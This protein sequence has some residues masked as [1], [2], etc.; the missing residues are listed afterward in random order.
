MT[1]QAGG[2]GEPPDKPDPFAPLPLATLPPV[3]RRGEPA[4]GPIATP[5][6][7]PGAAPAAPPVAPLAHEPVSWSPAPEPAPQAWTEPAV[8]V[9]GE[10]TGQSSGSVEPPLLPPT[11]NENALREAVGATPR[12]EPAP[13]KA[14]RRAAPPPSDPG[15][16]DGDDDGPR[17]RRSRRTVVVAALSILVGGGIAAT[18]V[19][20]KVNSARY[21][22][23]CEAEEVVIEQGRAF[24]PWGTR[25][26]DDPQWKPL[27]IPPE[28]ACHPRETEEPAELAGWYGRLLVDQATKLLTAREVT[29]VDDAEAILKQALLVSRSLRTDDDAKNSRTEIDRLLGDV[30]YWRASAR[31]RSAADTL[32]DAAKQF[33]AAA[34]QRPAHSTDASEWAAYARRLSD[35][36]RAGPSGSKAAAFPP[37]PPPE[38]ATGPTAPPG[39]ALPVEPDRG[40]GSA[41]PAPP[42]DAG[43]PTGGVLL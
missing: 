28:A 2:G 37:L 16:D 14:R 32:V 6:S 40:E 18:I 25:A 10:L 15:D 27:K 1:D 41:A 24:P 7:A 39:V 22:L 3:R 43:L 31:L 4:S 5:S 35:E 9:S 34:T 33:D 23:A 13:G 36:L 30:A 21:L 19:L 12:P 29:K 8:V 38:R 26:L 11:Y 17:K 20:G 42:P